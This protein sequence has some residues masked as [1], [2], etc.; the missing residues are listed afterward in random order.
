MRPIPKDKLEGLVQAGCSTGGVQA[1]PV[2][3]GD[4]GQCPRLFVTLTAAL[5]LGLKETGTWGVPELPQLAL[6]RLCERCWAP[7]CPQV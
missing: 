5:G 7:R 4:P 2:H 1:Q 6:P 3:I